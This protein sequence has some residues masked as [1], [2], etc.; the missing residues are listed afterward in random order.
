MKQ[1]AGTDRMITLPK[2]IINFIILSLNPSGFKAETCMER[3]L[4]NNNDRSKSNSI[5]TA[6]FD[7]PENASTYT[8]PLCFFLQFG[9]VQVLELIINSQPNAGPFL[10]DLITSL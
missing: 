8:V 2:N 9:L 4:I 6:I 7:Y 5:S 10:S 1:K 3:S